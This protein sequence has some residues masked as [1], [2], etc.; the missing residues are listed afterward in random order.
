M[1]RHIT[2]RKMSDMLT[3][4]TT[5]Q[6]ILDILYD[7]C[8]KAFGPDSEVIEN[9]KEVDDAMASTCCSLLAEYPDDARLHF[10]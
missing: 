4:L 8:L 6:N 1:A 9:L 7:E 2:A 3:K 5:A 10:S